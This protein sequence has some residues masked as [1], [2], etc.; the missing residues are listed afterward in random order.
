M[1]KHP[2]AVSLTARTLSAP[3]IGWVV[4]GAWGLYWNDLA[5]DALPSRHRRLATA[6]TRTVTAAG[7]R[8]QTSRWFAD[9]LA[10]EA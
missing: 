3:G 8:G 1:V 6:A 5:A 4:A 7:Q 10:P 2:L 9:R